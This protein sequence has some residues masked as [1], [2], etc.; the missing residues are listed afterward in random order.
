[1]MVEPTEPDRREH[2]GCP[3]CHRTF[4]SI[5]GYDI[6]RPCPE[7]SLKGKYVCEDGLYIL[8]RD[9]TEYRK[10]KEHMKKMRKGRGGEGLTI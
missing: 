5:H 9:I 1:M 7:T 3:N 8:K 4:W 6:H 2:Y 10:I